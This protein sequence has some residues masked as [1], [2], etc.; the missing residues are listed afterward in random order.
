VI[1]ILLLT[2]LFRPSGILPDRGEK[3][4][5]FALPVHLVAPCY[6]PFLSTHQHKLLKYR[7]IIQHLLSPP[8]G[9]E[10]A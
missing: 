1:G 10:F 3:L 9:T 6:L 2:H 5:V 4:A 8:T 7:A